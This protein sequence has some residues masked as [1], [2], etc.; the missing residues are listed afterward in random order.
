[1]LQF[2]THSVRIFS[3]VNHSESYRATYVK[4]F[5]GFEK[6][7]LPY[8]RIGAGAASKILL[9]AGAA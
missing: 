3:N 9:G 8:S 1:M 5:V 2:I 4:T 7:A 6:F